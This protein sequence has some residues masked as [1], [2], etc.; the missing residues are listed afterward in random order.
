MAQRLALRPLFKVCAR[1]TGYTG[2]GR[3]GGGVVEPRGDR[4]KLWATL[5]DSREAKGRRIVW[6][7]G[8]QLE[9]EP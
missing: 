5:A 6:G 8:T 2:G 7:V 1:E 4:E 9:P 3:R